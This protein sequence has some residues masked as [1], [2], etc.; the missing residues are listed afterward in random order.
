MQAFD[1]YADL[2]EWLGSRGAA[3]CVLGRAPDGAPVVAFKGGG[4]RD[5]AIFISAGTHSTEQAGVSAGAR[6]FDELE[7]DHKVYLIPSRD[8]MGMNGFSYVLGLSMGDVPEVG[9]VEQVR[10]ILKAEGEVLYEK[11][12]TVLAIIGE[13][14]YATCGLLGKFDKGVEFLEPLIGRRIFFPSSASGIEGTACCQRAYSLIVSPEGEILHLNRFHDTV[15][16]PVEPR[17]TRDLMARIQPGL[18]LDLHEY[19]GDGFWFSARHQQTDDDEEWERRMADAMI[20]AVRESGANLAPEEYLPGSFFEKGER[21]VFWLVAQQRGEGL[22]LADF[23]AS[24]YGP[25]FTIETGM[26][27]KGGFE[28]RVDTSVLAAKR[29]IAT[30]EERYA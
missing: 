26:T 6:L 30:F 11:G 17:C 8:P 25:A 23:A 24:K 29:A 1:Q 4:E 16:A 27:M 5:P 28:E 14:G 7:T 3:P 22:N 18:T 2:L 15:W 12:D 21:G 9:S 19:G 13:Y 20:N 10:E